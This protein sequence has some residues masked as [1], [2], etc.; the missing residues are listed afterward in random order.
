MFEPPDTIEDLASAIDRRF[1]APLRRPRTRRVGVE[2]E[3]PIWT[4]TSG[5]ATD[6]DAVH[7]ATEEFLS[8]F[9]FPDTAF[10]DMGRSIVSATPRRVMNC[11]STAPSTRWRFRLVPTRT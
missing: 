3:L 6:F 9:N 7:A 5:A 11:P 8:R 1:F 4:Q 2:L 10:D